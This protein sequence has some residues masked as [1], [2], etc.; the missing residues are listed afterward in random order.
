MHYVVHI[1]MHKTGATTIQRHLHANRKPYAL[2]GVEV[3]D[4]DSKG[5][6]THRLV[7]DHFEGRPS[8][9]VAQWL[10]APSSRTTVTRVISCEGFWAASEPAVQRMA[11]ALGRG[12]TVVAFVRDPVAQAVS[13]CAQLIKSKIKR[14]SLPDYLAGGRPAR[15]A[16]GYYNYDESL[17][18]WGEN[19]PG[20]R[21]LP[22][23]AADSVAAFIAAAPLPAIEAALTVPNE[24]LSMPAVCTAALLRINVMCLSGSMAEADAIR[25]KNVVRANADR[26]KALFETHARW[27]SVDTSEFAAAFVAA[28]P[29]ASDRLTVRGGAVPWIEEIEMSD[30]QFARALARLAV[31]RSS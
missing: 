31:S 30:A 8:P 11:Q 29:V 12:A 20:L 1:G 6:K 3:P 16:A 26:C 2:H 15:G 19:F 17:R 4:F 27:I 18:R 7:L 5:A 25:S 13:H 14:V 23:G 24:N 21:A 10:R 22:Y 28:N 9:V